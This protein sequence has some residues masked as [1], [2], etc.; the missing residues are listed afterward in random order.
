M[1]K[2]FRAICIGSVVVVLSA[3]GVCAQNLPA[4]PQGYVSDTAG[5]LSSAQ[6]QSL[7]TLAVELEQK[8]SAQMAVVTVATVKPDTIEQYAVR[9]FEQWGIGQKG[10][11]NGVLLLV[12]VQDREVRLEVGYGLEGALTDAM[13]K[14]IIERFMVPAFRQGAYDQGV[15]DGAV[16]VVSII[17]R[18][19]GVTVT[20]REQQIYQRVQAGQDSSS[21]ALGFIVFLGMVILFILNPRLFFYMMMFSAMGGGRSGSWSGGG[22]GFGGGFG[23]FGGGMSGGGGAS[24]RW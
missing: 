16:A 1:R 17:A 10:K 15:R 20:G 14:S 9:L 24:G 8:T 11:D 6:R 13:S 3:L 4:R 5:I 18:E 2:Q 19:F 21:D 7:E 22:G 12:A 23:G